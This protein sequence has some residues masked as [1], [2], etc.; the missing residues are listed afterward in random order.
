MIDS[1]RQGRLFGGELGAARSAVG[2]GEGQRAPLVLS[3]SSWPSWPQSREE[4]GGLMEAEQETQ[5]QE[6]IRQLRVTE[7]TCCAKGLGE[8]GTSL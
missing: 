3:L 4:G 8:R 2:W 5:V 1:R 6:Q 7:E